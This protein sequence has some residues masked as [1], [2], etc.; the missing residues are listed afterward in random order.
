MSS[1]SARLLGLALVFT[2]VARPHATDEWPRFRGL[3]AGVADD[4]ARLPE[5]WSPT[6]NIAWTLDLPGLSWSSPVVQGDH[7]FVTSAIS[8][9]V[10]PP[11]EK[12]LFDPG[13]QQHGNTHT[14]SAQT[15]VVYDVDFETGKIRWSREIGQLV[16]K[17]GR[18]VKNSFASETAVIDGDASTST[19]AASGWSQRST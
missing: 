6:T 9:G 19:S 12:G 4:D 13:D 8:A 7:I 15:W 2:F 18:H 17:I 14:R 16:P 10:E 3:Q 5:T 11:P 1:V